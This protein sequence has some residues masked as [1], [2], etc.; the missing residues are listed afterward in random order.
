[1]PKKRI[2][3]DKYEFYSSIGLSVVPD[4]F[5]S[6][7]TEPHSHESTYEIFICLRGRISIEVNSKLHELSEGDILAI[8]PGA[9]HHSLNVAEGSI[10]PCLTLDV[11]KSD[12]ADEFQKI[13][14]PCV[15]LKANDFVM[16]LC[17]SLHTERD[18][19]DRFSSEIV[20]IKY[21]L[22]I[23][24]IISRVL[25]TNSNNKS[26]LDKHRDKLE[27]IDNFFQNHE[28]YNRSA[29]DLADMIHVSTR[30]LNRILI[31]QY[32]FNFSEKMTRHRL[33]RA[34]WLLRNTNIPIEDIYQEI[35]YTSRSSFFKAFKAYAGI[36]PNQYRNS[37]IK[38]KKK[39][40]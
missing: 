35:C 19:L 7:T 27:I 40:D 15:S 12:S 28:N 4:V 33:A 38:I 31:S 14:Y 24:E 13:V 21:Q 32:G 20:E 11:I 18:Y 8:A 1:M 37:F 29:N 36:T 30:H 5:N 17:L 22:F 6:Y 10:I 26:T 9:K 3:F 34:S 39:A 25:K 16:A 23:A 2:T